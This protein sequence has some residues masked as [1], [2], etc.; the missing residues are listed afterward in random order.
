MI[1]HRTLKIPRILIA[2]T[3]SGTGK[4]TVTCALLRALVWQGLKVAALKCGP[5]FIDPM[6]HREVIGAKSGNLDIFLSGEEGVKFLLAKNSENADISILEGVMG[7]FD[8]ISFGSWEG[9]SYHIAKATQTPS[10]LIVNTRGMGRSLKA[11]LRGFL[12]EGEGTLCG[13][14][15]DCCREEMYFSYRDVA[16]ELRINSY[17]F[18]P[19]LPG[20]LLKSRHLGLVTAREIS[21]IDHKLD[22]LGNAAKKSL[23]LKG[24]V[25]L[26]LSAPPLSVQDLWRDVKK[27]F[28]VR[29]GV[30]KDQAFCFYY[31]DELDLFIEF[32]AKIIFFS[33]LND[34]ALPQDLDGIYLPGGYPEEYC[35]TL[36]EN[37]PMRKSIFTAVSAGMPTLAECGGFMY[38]LEKIKRGDGTSYPMV[39]ALPGKAF[40]TDRLSRFGYKTIIALKDNLLCKKEEKLP[41][42]EFHYSDSSNNGGDFFCEKRGKIEY[43]I[44]ASESLFAGYPHFNLSVRPYNVE[45]F[46]SKCMD[47]RFKRNNF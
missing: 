13:V 44:H 10:V 28:P 26:A 38:L 41:C 7:Y 43:M 45:R 20:A 39:G 5:D 46:L 3:A 29:L 27:N 34:S 35:S 42:H 32:G 17:G 25:D 1:S 33:P 19:P 37:S 31:E 11:I 14:I 30:A 9:S 8:G 36:S 40:M 22:I 21:D 24:L 12:E 2:G 47:Y 16:K 18:L 15:F 23:D 6:F 4:T